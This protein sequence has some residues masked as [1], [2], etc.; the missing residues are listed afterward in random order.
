M[1]YIGLSIEKNMYFG[2][3]KELILLARELRNNMT[4]A[5]ESLWSR[6]RRQQLGGEI[7]R[8][9][10]PI[11]I[12]IVDFYCHKHKLVIEIDGGIHE[13]P[14]IKERDDNRTFELENFGLKVIR[15][16]NDEVLYEPEKVLLGIKQH[17][18]L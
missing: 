11:D 4:R 10:H 6:L 2:A 7:F 3:K 13:H 17:L 12:F 14:D 15:F 5:E 9:Q 1:A 8:R 16:T 18:I